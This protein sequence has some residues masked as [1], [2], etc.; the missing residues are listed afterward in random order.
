MV[1]IMLLYC[2]VWQFMFTLAGVCVTPKYWLVVLG[3]AFFPDVIIQLI[4]TAVHIG[5]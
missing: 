1:N 3:S 4:G 2:I 5:S